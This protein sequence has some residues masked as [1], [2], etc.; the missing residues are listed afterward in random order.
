MVI[1]FLHDCHRQPGRRATLQ[2][3]RRRLA[4]L[5]A[6][7]RQS[8][9]SLA[10]SLL[11]QLA[12]DNNPH[13]LAH[14]LRTRRFQRF[15]ALVSGLTSPV[16]ILD[17]G[18]TSGFWERRGWAGRNDIQI[19]TLNLVAEEPRHSNIK[20]LVGDAT[21]LGQFADGGFDVA[22]SNSLIEHLRTF[23]KQRHM[24]GEIQRVGKAFWVQTPS[25]WFPVEPHFH[26]PGWQWMP[27]PLRVAMLRRWRCGWIG[28]CND[29]L[30][31]RDMVQEVRLMTKSELQSLFPG[32]TLVPEYF[33]GLVKSWIAIGGFSQRLQ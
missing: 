11:R 29:P 7:P 32:A 25:F 28:P 30:R 23:E 8:G 12:D 5:P 22:F 6:A 2:E 1:P 27:V 16:H 9:M 14:K 24:A 18:G 19:T 15:E 17:L 13:S 4:G 10:D 33:C 3:A 31:A 21:D 26:V 20:P